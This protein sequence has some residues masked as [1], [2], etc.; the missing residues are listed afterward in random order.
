MAEARL[1]TGLDELGPDECFRLLAEHRVGRLAMVAEGGRLEIFPVNYLLSGRRVLF[2]TDAG[3]KLTASTG[4]GV[5]FEID[6][7][8]H[9]AETGWSVI[10]RGVARQWDPRQFPNKPSTWVRSVKPFLVA[11]DPIEVTGRRIAGAPQA[12]GSQSSG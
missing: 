1:N 10:V 5:V 12:S 4:R 7:A 6:S 2:W 8:D 3:T 9:E 11:I